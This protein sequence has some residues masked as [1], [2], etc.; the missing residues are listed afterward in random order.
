[1]PFSVKSLDMFSNIFK[2][3][4]SKCII[5]NNN[6]KEMLQQIQVCIHICV[7]PDEILLHYHIVHKTVHVKKCIL[8]RND[9]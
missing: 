1:M 8:S 6:N 7:C 3:T 4:T 2:S 5:S 9:M